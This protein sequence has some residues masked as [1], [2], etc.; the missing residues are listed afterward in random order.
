VADKRLDSLR[1]A[2]DEAGLELAPELV[3]RARQEAL[4]RATALLA[5]AMTRSMLEHAERHLPVGSPRRARAGPT[6]QTARDDSSAASGAAAGELAHYVYGV[7]RAGE[8]SSPELPAGVDPD[9]RPAI[10]EHGSLAAIVSVVPLE[11][12]GEEQLRENLNDV[13]WLERVARAHESVLDAAIA[14]TTVVPLRICTLYRGEEQVREM[15]DRERVVFEEALRRLDGKSEFG[16]KVVADPGALES[17]V[18][19]GDEAEVDAPTSPGTAYMRGQSRAR[20]RREDAEAVGAEWAERI[21][22][23]A[24]SNAAEAVLNPIQNPEVS[25]HVGDMLLNGAYLVDRS[26][27]PAFRGEVQAL[28]EEFRGVGASVELTGPWPP[29]NFVTGSLEA[30]A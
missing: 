22:H 12:F 16:V 1:G 19:A 15:L 11:E 28:A 6:G 2:I 27:E 18:E 4:E 30:S 9:A 24:A 25:G 17:A 23:R 14:A 26:E 29:Y 7:L 13:E 21:H 10:V 20:H 8:G 5:D 3:R